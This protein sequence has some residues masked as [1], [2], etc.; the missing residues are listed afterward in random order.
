M[1]TWYDLWPKRRDAG[2][3]SLA[4]GDAVILVPGG[5]RTWIAIG[6]TDMRLGMHRLAM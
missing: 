2:N 5:V 4:A 6:Y 1:S 3:A